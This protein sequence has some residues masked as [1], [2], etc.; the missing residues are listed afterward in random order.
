VWGKHKKE[1]N[2]PAYAIKS[3]RYISDRKTLYFKTS[4]PAGDICEAI[5][6]FKEVHRH[7]RVTGIDCNDNERIVRQDRAWYIPNTAAA[8]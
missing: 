4:V 8:R 3:S 5:A 7:E 1:S 6:N 2:M